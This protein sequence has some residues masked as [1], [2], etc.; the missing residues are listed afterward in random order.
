MIFFGE[1]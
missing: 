1:I